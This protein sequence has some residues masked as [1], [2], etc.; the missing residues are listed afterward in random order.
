M[1]YHSHGCFQ[2]NRILIKDRLL[3]LSGINFIQ[4]TEDMVSSEYSF[5][6]L[7][8]HCLTT[9]STAFS[10]YWQCS[11]CFPNVSAY[12]VSYQGSQGLVDSSPVLILDARFFPMSLNVAT[13]SLIVCSQFIH[14]FIM[15]NQKRLF[16]LKIMKKSIDV[17]L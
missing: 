15:S 3:K 9:E 11:E 10:L 7:H 17:F 1:N 4:V 13:F 16:S 2:S 5:G 6:R 14:L 12:C 8:D